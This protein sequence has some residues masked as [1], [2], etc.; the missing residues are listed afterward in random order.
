MAKFE[1][2][3][4]AR[5]V[6]AFIVVGLIG[7]VAWNLYGKDKLASMRSGA[8]PVAVAPESAGAGGG[9]GAGAGAPVQS[10]PVRVA[11]ASKALG[12]AANPLRV[13]IV[14]FHG[15]GPALVANGNS[16]TTQPGS[17]Y[18]KLGLHVEFVINDDVP[19]L[20]TLF[21][22][23]S[24]Q[25]AWRTSD[26]WA[27]EQPNLRNN[28]LDA[29]GLLIVDN[30]RGADAV[31]VRDPSIT[32]I[33]GLPG[34]Q[35]AFL[36]YSPSHGLL[37]YATDNSSLTAR[38]KKRIKHVY[39]KTEEGTAG[40]RAAFVSGSVDAAVLWDADLSLALKAVPGSRVVYSTETATNLIY[41]LM[42]CNQAELAKPENEEVFQRFVDGWLEGVTYSLANQD[43]VVDALI[44]TEPVYKALATQNGKPFI[45]GLFKN[46]LWTDLANNARILG[47][48]GGTN[49]YERVYAT[50]DQIY[51]A[52]GALANPKSPVVAPQDSFDYRFIKKALARSAEAKAVAARP[53]EVYTEKDRAAAM[54]APA[55]V[56]KPVL[57]TFNS[58][59]ADLSKRAQ[60]VI[61]KEMVP[62]IESNDKAYIEISGNTDS[63]GSA[64]A[65]RALSQQ[66]A[67]SVLEYLS[68][69]WNFSRA[70]FR[71]VGAGSSRPLCDEGNPAAA[72]LSLDDCRAL[73]RST[74]LAIFSGK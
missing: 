6:I 73:N 35:V 71:V 72:E 57:V 47:L 12:S 34:K 68:S 38:D 5:G 46:L 25:C 22:S 42:V 10:T 27:Q 29:K 13:S 50:F 55:V 54:A 1:T 26:F 11:S 9:A 31:I 64:A 58:G 16:L 62:F 32:S 3:G 39:I 53:V 59:S 63:V 69:Q 20:T 60:A 44:A 51:R 37:T 43:Q 21:E 14:S 23:K 52:E 30:T 18:D 65:N 33:E 70:R 36:Q 40:V 15:Y 56:T 66:R 74:R 48:A 49:H 2:T 28:Q 61:D 67:N 17:M 41:D 7:S 19:T 4:L 45:K 8:A 24:A